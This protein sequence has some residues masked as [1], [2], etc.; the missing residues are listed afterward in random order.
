VLIEPL[1][2]QE[3]VLQARGETR[4]VRHITGHLRVQEDPNR[5]SA[6]HFPEERTD[7]KDAFQYGSS[8][9]ELRDNSVVYFG[10]VSI[11]SK[12]ILAPSDSNR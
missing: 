12:R 6:A 8:G 7:W 1:C 11:V 10:D 5:F 4:I 2:P 3:A 9:S